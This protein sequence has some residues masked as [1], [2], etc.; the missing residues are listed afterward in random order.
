V[1]GESHFDENA[2][3]GLLA[4]SD[5][6]ITLSQIFANQ[7]GFLGASLAS[8][9]KIVISDSYFDGNVGGWGLVADSDESVTLN[10]VSASNNLNGDG[11]LLGT[12]GNATIICSQFTGNL[13]VGVDGSAVDGTFTLDDVTFGGNGL[14]YDGT[15]VFASGGCKIVSGKNHKSHALP[16]HIVPVGGGEQ[17]DLDCGAYSGTM[18]ILPNGDRVTIPCPI[19]DHGVLT[20]KTQS[21]LPAPLDA[22]FGFASALE[23]QVIR[24]GEPVS[25]THTGMIIDFLI[26]DEQAGGN[27][28]IL[29]WDPL[30]SQWVE[31]I[32]GFE[33]HDGRFV[34]TSSFTGVF[35]LV[36]K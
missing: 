1:I 19:K 28:A 14:D 17:I 16:L 12:F 25:E 13:G 24:D 31:V 6:S 10:Y 30:Q 33:T 3:V 18:L 7:N 36:T 9:G 4:T 26:P 32:N 23:V 35:V 15:P 8:T 20:G 27:L 29:H 5:N 21:Q 11:A 34:A 2:I 22:A